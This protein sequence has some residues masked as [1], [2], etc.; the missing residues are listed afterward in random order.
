[1]K[2]YKCHNL[3]IEKYSKSKRINTF[4]SFYNT[5]P[6][7]ES[8]KS[9]I[10]KFPLMLDI[11]LTNHCNADCLFCSR[12]LMTR[13]KGFMSMELIEKILT[14]IRSRKTPVRFIRYGEPLL[15]PNFCEILDSFNKNNIPVHI[16]TNSQLLNE[17]KIKSIIDS[18]V[19]SIIFS[20]QGANKN[21]YEKI[22]K[23]C[24]WDTTIENI[25]KLADRRGDNPFP[26]LMVTSTMTNETPKEIK[27]FSEYFV[28]IVDAVSCGV[29]NLGHL[30]AKKKTEHL[31][32]YLEDYKYKTR[33]LIKCREVLTKM[34]VDWDGTVV[35]CCGDYN[36]ELFVGHFPKHSLQDIWLN[37]SHYKEIREN[38]A[39][40]NRAY[41]LCQMCSPRYKG[42]Y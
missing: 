22:R 14:E 6:F 37:S 42:D 39:N 38:L 41:K 10:P 12:R 27:E 13:K 36:Q 2:K 20:F 18:E 7:K 24:K 26:Y 25:K 11:E 3:I 40:G 23:G 35:A 30:I 29:T 17:K 31:E 32:G 34:A 28:N 1:M 19:K 21:G 4:E 8:R 33:R 9:F 15:H 5:A 16:S